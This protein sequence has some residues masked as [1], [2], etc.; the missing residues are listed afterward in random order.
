MQNNP[1]ADLS[2]ILNCY[3]E[4]GCVGI[5]EVCASLPFTDPLY[6]NLFHHAGE[7]GLPV[8][9]HLSPKK[10]GLYGVIDKPELP[11]LE[12]VLNE[13][14]KTKFI[15][16]APAFWNAIDADV[17][18]QKARNGYPKG[19]IKNK[20]A[21]W[22]LMETYPNLYGDFSAGSGHNAL[23]RDPEKGVEFIKKFNKKI[24]FG[25][26]MFMVKKAP[27]DHLVMMKELLESKKISKAVYEN[28]MH[29][30]FERVFPTA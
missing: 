25:T 21:L 23:T 20:G 30:N 7:C 3:K 28:I 9:F 6:K 27:P 5:G 22:R 12:E 15:G 26:D 13:F 24:F 14:P 4:L 16:H 29:R 18:S 10:R 17:K 1:D 11:G 2:I 8:L 19:E